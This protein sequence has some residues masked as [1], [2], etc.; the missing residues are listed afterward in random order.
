[1]A[2]SPQQSSPTWAKVVSTVF[3]PFLMPLFTLVLLYLSDPILHL[4][5][6]AFI[7]LLV[8]LA[9]NTVAPAISL[10]VMHKRG[11]ISDLEIRNRSQRSWPFLVV[12]AYYTLTWFIAGSG[13]N[14]RMIPGV[15]MGLL[16]GLI[17]AIAGAILIT[18]WFKLSM[19]GMGVGGTL[20]ALVA[21]QTL[22][23]SPSLTLDLMLVLIA[24]A[25]GWSRLALGV[26]THREVYAGTIY[27]FVVVFAAVLLG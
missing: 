23:F 21:V 7:Y 4:H 6:A 11:A 16:T 9:V 3:H 20:G 19:H 1:M 22:H 15:Y 18:R 8:V 10:Y 26:H 12:L 13:D 5:F 27:G 25:V 2:S 24:G 17:A 14:A